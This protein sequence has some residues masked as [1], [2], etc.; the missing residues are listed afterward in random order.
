MTFD[1]GALGTTLKAKHSSPMHGDDPNN[2]SHTSVLHNQQV[3]NY[4]DRN[5]HGPVNVSHEIASANELNMF[6]PKEQ[7]G[8][9]YDVS[10]SLDNDLQTSQLRPFNNAAN[11]QILVSNEK[12]EDQIRFYQSGQKDQ[13]RVASIAAAQAAA[14]K[15]SQ[16]DAS[17]MRLNKQ[18]L[19][20]RPGVR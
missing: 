4:G 14:A 18:Y 10:C 1:Q 7:I 5:A 11:N 17:Q 12:E 9:Y 6:V 15:P 3:P 20:K 2:F 8:N 13:M 16:V 19:S